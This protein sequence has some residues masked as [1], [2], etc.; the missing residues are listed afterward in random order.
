MIRHI[1]FDLDGTLLDTRDQIVESILACLPKA[2]RTEKTRR[3]LYQDEGGSPRSILK[4]FGVNGL[5]QYWKHHASLA[6][7]SRCF[8]SDTTSIL[9]ALWDEGLSP[10]LNSKMVLVRVSH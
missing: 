10:D 3:A 2:L 8:F 7:K 5:E 9:R 1:A 6:A 4:Q